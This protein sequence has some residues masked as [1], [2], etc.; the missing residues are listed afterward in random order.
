MI[1]PSLRATARRLVPARVK[2]TIHS[3]RDAVAT[4]PIDDATLAHYRAEPDGS[5][6]PRVTFVLPNLSPAIAFGGVTTGMDIVVRLA[7]AMRASGPLDLRLVLSDP[8]ASTTPELFVRAAAGA[9]IEGDAIE[10]LRV[11]AADQRIGAR[12]R[13]AFVTYNFWT[14]LNVAPLRAAQAA[15][16]DVPLRPLLYLIQEYEPHLFAFSSA[17]LLAR[18]AYDTVPRLWGIFNS[19]NLKAYFDEM[20]HLAERGFV[21]EPLV[22]NALRPY[23]DR[24]EQSPRSNRIVVYGRPQV[25]RNCFPAVVRGLRRWAADNPEFSDWEV[26]S[27]G[28]P[29]RPIA[30]DA[31]RTMAS[32]GKLSLDAYATLMLGSS[33]GLSLMASPH[34]SYPPL[35]MAHM[36]L[37][38]VT[39]SYP[40][41]D[42]SGWHPN[43]IS[44][45]SIAEGPLAAALA[46]ACRRAAGPPSSARVPS[47]VRDDDYPFMAQLAEALV[48][49]LAR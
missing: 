26:V 3:F 10:V 42:L 28:M 13:E 11:T 18:E 7:A 20:G 40:C 47:Y 41:K 4:L 29:H 39:N 30:L 17:H 21:F 32:V 23:L 6:V 48:A 31:G 49:E 2:R 12:R 33:V 16:H 9:G 8:D 38:T 44:T 5:P 14:T 25:E 22:S 36:G 35:E 15:M 46:E 37:R 24:V 45:D 34:P 1:R 19:S 27:A 43:I